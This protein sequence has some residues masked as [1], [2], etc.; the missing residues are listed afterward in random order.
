[1]IPRF[2]LPVGPMVAAVGACHAV[3]AWWWS[4]TPWGAWCGAL[5]ILCACLGYGRLL[6]HLTG[7]AA[8]LP[9]AATS[10]LAV[11]L[12]L[13]LPLAW[14]GVLTRPVQLG[15]IGLGIAVA[16]IPGPAD[17]IRRGSLPRSVV[18]LTAAAGAVL[19]AIRIASVAT[20]VIDEQL[21]HVFEIA[22]LWGT[23]RLPSMSHQ[24]GLQ[25]IGE[26]YFALAGGTH[27]A[28]LFD[29]GVCAALVL[30]VLASTIASS[31][32][33]IALPLFIVVAIQIFLVPEARALGFSRWSATLL[34]VALFV[35]LR[36]NARAQLLACG[37]ALAAVRHEY[38]LLAAPYLIR[39][40]VGPRPGSRDR[41]VV[42]ALWV[43]AVAALKLW[44]G[45]PAALALGKATATLLAIPLAFVVLSV[46]GRFT[47]HDPLFVTFTGCF[48][49][50][51]GAALGIAPRSSL[52]WP[53]LF[54]AWYGAA[55]AVVATI[56]STIFTRSLRAPQ[57]GRVHLGSAMV[58]VTLTT[59]QM[60]LVPAFTP[61]RRTRM[62][63][64]FANAVVELRYLKTEGYDTRAAE[65]VRAAQDLVPAG[66]PL[67]FWG[68]H[69]G[70]LDF[71]RNPIR[72]VSWGGKR[73]LPPLAPSSLDGLEYLVIEEVQPPGPPPKDR[74]G[75]GSLSPVTTV[76]SRVERRDHVGSIAVYRV[77]R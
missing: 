45:A 11:L 40:F 39:A 54:A 14:V 42:G 33:P 43:V 50:T 15:A 5:A 44:G 7:T 26:S 47:I 18:V 41:V 69:G 22:R 16:A 12:V 2:A 1:M 65:R 68:L 8:P 70:Q 34:H 67:G 61:A 36:A 9:W 53:T 71:T 37:I 23:G 38:A 63:E 6:G 4:G 20:P 55:L 21:D 48:A 73:F 3:G 77:L 31:K 52:T 30:A 76:T 66:A 60:I 28:G 64:R 13:S 27:T 62:R 59:A 72:N 49:I 35:A 57:P 58:L 17:D 74:W 24:L 56:D 10:G 75:P 19:I 51:L 25:L 46:I 32:D 29:G